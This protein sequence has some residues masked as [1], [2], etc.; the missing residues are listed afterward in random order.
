MS[1]SFEHHTWPFL[2]DVLQ[3]ER[4]M[5]QGL[6]VAELGN[7]R[8][9]PDVF[10]KHLMTPNDTPPPREINRL[11]LPAKVFFQRMGASYVAIDINGRDG[12]L[13]LDLGKPLPKEYHGQFDL[14]TNIGTAEHVETG[15]EQCFENI[16]ALC[17]VGGL[18]IHAMPETG[19]WPK[20]CKI[21]YTAE[22]LEAYARGCGYS[23]VQST[24]TGEPGWRMLQVA[25]RKTEAAFA[26]PT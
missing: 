12:T 19:S 23:V 11:Q 18:M 26:W 2:I 20:H 17:R 13:K 21:H 6:R 10:S 25:L 14:V 5:F 9:Y 1:Y 24:T 4:I 8:I 15:Q 16:H 22:W 7:Q 3:Q